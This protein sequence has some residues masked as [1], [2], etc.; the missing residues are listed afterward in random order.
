MQALIT[1]NNAFRLVAT[2]LLSYI[3]PKAFVGR[4]SPMQLRDIAEPTLPAP[5]W[6]VAK[7]LLC[8]LCGSDYKQVFMNGRIDNPMTSMI[9]WPQVLG[10]E[11]VA[12]VTRIGEK[13]ST[14]RVGERVLLNPWLSCVTRGLPSCT[15]CQQGKLAQCLNFGTGHIERGIHHGNSASATGGFA[16]QV[17]GHESQWF[18]IPDAISDEAAVLGDPFSVSFHAILKAPPQEHGT[19]L[20]YGCGTLGLLAIAILRAIHPT[21]KILA[22]ARFDHQAQLAK[23]LGAHV[24]LPHHPTKQL[25][26]AIAAET[27]ADLNEPWAG[28][29][30]LNGGVDVVYDTVSSAE[31][32]EVGLRVTRSLGAMVIIGV[33]PSTTFEWTPLYFKEISIF[34]SN[35]F[36]IEEFEGQRKHAMEWYFEFIEQRGLDVTP[37]ITHHYAMRDYRDAFMTCYDQGKSCAVKVLFNSFA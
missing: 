18:P 23:K 26:H 5:D 25:V 9:S 4:Q 34:G 31:T 17:P 1:T 24:V 19:V 20:V 28:L 36:G 7:T 35:G 29:P 21:V 10:H 22:V 11:V 2:K 14:R 37:I 6:L 15:F 30:M 32:M 12:E 8:G 13:V 16:E 3:S 33:E 27:S